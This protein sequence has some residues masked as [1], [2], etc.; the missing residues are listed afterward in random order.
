MASEDAEQLPLLHLKL[1]FLALE[2]PACILALARKAGGGSVTPHIQNFILESCIGTNVGQIQDYTY[3]KIILKK[4][5]AEAELSSDIVIDGLYEE[6]AR[7]MSS[8]ANN[9]SLNMSGKICKEISFLSPTYNNV[10][11]NQVSLVARLSCS[12]NMLEGDTGCSLW[13]S[14]LF[15]SEFI[16]SFPKLFS[17]KRCFEQLGSGVGLVG[18]CLNYVGASKVILTDGDA[19]TLINMKANMEMNNLYAEDSELVKESKNKVECKYLSWEEASESD[20]WDCRTDLVLGAD[21]IYNPSCVPHLV[22]VLSTLL[23]RE[24]GRCETVNVGR[25]EEPVN[26]V[27]WNG[28]TRGPLAYMATVIRN[29]DTFN[30]FAKAAADA[31]LSVVNITGAAAPSSFLP[32]MLSYE[33]S[34]VQLLEIT[35]LS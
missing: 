7:C 17:K 30:C 15:L 20:L 14:S 21:I 16:L 35:S 29:A 19:S 26:E 9:S 22:R 3:V 34:S 23:G 1:A 18:V 13:P 28:A 12:T 6:F 27:P 32:Y 11:S 24:D 31:K 4:V 33:R 10:S 25:D 2:P 5:I 8:K